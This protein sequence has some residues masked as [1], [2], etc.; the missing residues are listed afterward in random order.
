MP[1]PSHPPTSRR[2]TIEDVRVEAT[3]R[4]RA[5]CWRTSSAS[6]QRSRRGCANADRSGGWTSGSDGSDA[7]SCWRT[8]GKREVTF[9]HGTRGKNRQ[10]FGAFSATI[11]D[12]Q[13]T[14]KYQAFVKICHHIQTPYNYNKT[15]PPLDTF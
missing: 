6:P 13:N 10:D 1:P 14:T 8:N 15:I 7:P 2:V 9:R 5:P 11:S 3:H 12:V 4:G